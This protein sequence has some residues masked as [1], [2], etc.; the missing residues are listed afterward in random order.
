MKNLII[1]LLEKITKE[2]KAD[3]T[4]LSEEELLTVAKCL[5]DINT[6]QKTEFSRTEAYK[7]LRISNSSFGD[8]VRKGILPKGVKLPGKGPIW[9]K[10]DLDA[11]VNKEKKVN[12]H[13]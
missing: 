12:T 2:F 3:N 1:N 4:N 8:K 6:V 7:Y 10:K 9:Y 13:I 11:Y 5:S